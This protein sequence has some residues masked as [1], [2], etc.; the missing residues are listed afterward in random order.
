LC[1]SSVRQGE[2]IIVTDNGQPVVRVVAAG[3]DAM[4]DRLERDGLLRRGRARR[5]AAMIEVEAAPGDST[6]EVSR[7]RDR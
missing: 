1:R 4:L 6:D 3:G 2:D 7:G 5:P